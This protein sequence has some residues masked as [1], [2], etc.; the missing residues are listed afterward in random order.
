ML[1][2]E[3]MDR[4][5]KELQRR[6]LQ[7]PQDLS[8][9]KLYLS[10]LVRAGQLETAKRV[11]IEIIRIKEG[12]DKKDSLVLED[13]DKQ[14]FEVTVSYHDARNA[15]FSLDKQSGKIDMLWHE[16][17]YPSVLKDMLSD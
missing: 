3:V 11:A 9:H 2:I 7:D 4:K 13:A 1:G 10:A 6:V 14:F 17:S 12:L 5:L 15:C 8:I 16:D